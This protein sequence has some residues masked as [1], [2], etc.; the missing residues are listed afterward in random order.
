MLLCNLHEFYTEF[1]KGDL[2]VDVGLTKFFSLHPKSVCQCWIYWYPFSL[3][4]HQNAI[5][6]VNVSHG[7]S[8]LMAKVACNQE[9][10]C[11]THRCSPC[12]GKKYLVPLL[13]SMLSNLDDLLKHWKNTNCS[14]FI[15]QSVLVEEYK[16]LFVLLEWLYTCIAKC[17][18]KYLKKLKDSLPDNEC[19]ILGDFTKNYQFVIQDEISKN[20]SQKKNCILHPIVISKI[21]TPI[22]LFRTWKMICAYRTVAHIYL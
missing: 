16:E 19:I 6:L 17:Q 4:H 2:I 21:T 15:T 3:S 14:K 11:M 9:N 12:T 5:F 1:K 18:T 13:D 20:I 8:H 22:S 7:M 10:E